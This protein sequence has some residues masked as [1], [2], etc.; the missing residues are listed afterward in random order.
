MKTKILYLPILVIMLFGLAGLV[1]G[2]DGTSTFVE[3]DDSEYIGPGIFIVNVTTEH[4]GNGTDNCSVTISSAKAGSSYT[5]RLLNGTY[6]NS[7]AYANITIA[8]FSAYVDADDYQFSG[9]CYNDTNSET[10]TAVTGITIDTTKPVCTQ[11]NLASDIT[12]DPDVFTTDTVVTATNATACWVNFGSNSYSI[13]ETSDVC[14]FTGL[15]GVPDGIYDVTFYTS[16]GT[17]TTLCTQLTDVQIKNPRPM[18]GLI[19]RVLLDESIDGGAESLREQATTRM[20]G[21]TPKNTGVVAI[22]IIVIIV[23]IYY[24]QKK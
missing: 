22:V 1:S 17:N 3:P 24:S 20:P 8:N 5:V 18:G 21:G 13:I 7:P 11:S 4:L 2:T 16:D 19:K 14:T 23:A 10:I 15:S 6:G 9:T 12:Y